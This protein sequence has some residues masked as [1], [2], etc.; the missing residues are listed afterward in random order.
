MLFFNLDIRRI[1]SYEKKNFKRL[2]RSFRL[3]PLQLQVRVQTTATFKLANLIEDVHIFPVSAPEL[4]TYL[5][6]NQS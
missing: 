5:N 6:P 3:T 1:I 2:S 4:N